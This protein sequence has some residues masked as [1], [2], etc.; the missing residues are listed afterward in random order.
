[1]PKSWHTPRWRFIAMQGFM[2]IVLCGAI[3]LA[4]LVDSV[5][6]RANAITMSDP[7]E[8]SPITFELP[9]DWRI[10]PT[11]TGAGREADEQGGLGRKL[12]VTVQHVPRIFSP[13][14]Y[15]ER[16]GQLPQNLDQVEF[17]PFTIAGF[18][19]ICARWMGLKWDASGTTVPH[20]AFCFCVVLPSYDAVTIRL[21]KPAALESADLRVL[22]FVLGSLR[23]PSQTPVSGNS[24]DLDGGA[25]IAVPDDFLIYPQPDPLRSD[26][27]ILRT[28]DDGGWI[29]AQFIPILAVDESNQTSLREALEINEGLDPRDPG[30]AGK[31]LNANFTTENNSRIKIDPGDSSDLLIERRAYV[32]PGQGS[33]ALLVLLTAQAPAGDSELDEAVS[34]LT[35]AIQIKSSADLPT[36][37]KAG[38]A[39]EPGKSSHSL[40]GEQWW[41]WTRAG[42]TEGWSHFFPDSSG[43]SPTLQTVRHG[44]E[45]G[46]IRITQRWGLGNTPAGFWAS[47]ARFDGTDQ[48][49]FLL[50]SNIAGGQI[51]TQIRLVDTQST[52]V[53]L[54][55]GFVSSAAFPQMLSSID[56]PAAVW[57]DRFIGCEAELLPWPILL[58]MQSVSASQG[59]CVEAEVN[60]TGQLS[61]WYFDKDGSLDHADF[62]G[63]WSLR[64]ATTA[65][66]QSAV[67]GDDA[68]TLQGP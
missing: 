23:A 7:I 58:R 52:T 68:L 13:V 10:A 28:T 47:V 40:A 62:A 29:S 33:S 34:Q 38:K 67:A 14:E 45:G 60:G 66:I 64:T 26:R 61:R 6:R 8:L 51:T 15:L 25:H 27:T 63:G 56:S 37:L 54:P 16:T 31:W 24:I 9:A 43:K 2:W 36:M 44:W 49:T 22:Q 21:D 32:F 3:G 65:E 19:G 57:T 5:V 59:T 18:P 46:A 39:A 42:K 20:G 55:D 11:P 17:S 35:G 30:Q 41:L 4:A 48:P 53:A 50:Q 12:T 1:M